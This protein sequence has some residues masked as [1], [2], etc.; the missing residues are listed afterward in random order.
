MIMGVLGWWYGR[1]LTQFVAWLKTRLSGTA[2]AFSLDLMLKTLFAP[3]RQ[4]GNEA[5]TKTGYELWLERV[6]SKLISRLV[7]FFMRTIM[8][9][10]G[11]IL[12]ALQTA[13]SLLAFALYLTVP[14]WWAIIIG[15]L[16][17]L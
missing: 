13:A 1:G 2:D 9:I 14:W 7:G 16:I 11:L 15:A 4:I 5:S 3:F 12:L 17:W 8:I 6:T 10:I